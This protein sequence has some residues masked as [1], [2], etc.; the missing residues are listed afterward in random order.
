[1]IVSHTG[2]HYVIQNASYNA[3]I[4][5]GQSVAVGF[6]AAPGH[7][8]SGPAGYI[9]NGVSLGSAASSGVVQASSVARHVIGVDP[10][11]HHGLVTNQHKKGRRAHKGM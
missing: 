1:V 3:S 8:A 9:L 5:P 7:P 2:K 10:Q 11:T 4:A 6:N